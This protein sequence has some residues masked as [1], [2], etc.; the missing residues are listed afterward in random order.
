[1]RRLMMVSPQLI[2]EHPPELTTESDL[3]ESGPIEGYDC[4][5]WLYDLGVISN[6]F[7]ANVDHSLRGPVIRSPDGTLFYFGNNY[8]RPSWYQSGVTLRF[9][10][11]RKYA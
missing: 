3:I 2:Y 8:G 9:I 4:Y 6:P 5:A 1:M 11:A 7:V 10:K